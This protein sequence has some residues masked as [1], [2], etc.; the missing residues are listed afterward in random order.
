MCLVFLAYFV[1]PD[2]ERRNTVDV[3]LTQIYLF[4]LYGLTFWPPL[5]CDLRPTLRDSAWNINTAE[6]RDNQE[7]WLLASIT[8]ARKQP[9]RQDERPAS[10]GAGLSEGV[11]SLKCSVHLQRLPIL[12]NFP[13]PV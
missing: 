8:M 3:S 11:P 10:G 4:F 7:K 9:V 5:P 1:R 2:A 13:N 6:G 12:P